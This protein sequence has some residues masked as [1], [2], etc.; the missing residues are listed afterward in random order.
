MVKGLTLGL[1]T[2]ALAAAASAATSYNV[3][4]FEPVVV[5]GTSLKPGEYKVEV[6]ND[7]ATIKRGKTLDESPV[8]IE[9]NEVK[10]PSTSV[11]LVGTQVEEIRV[12]GTKTKL[13]FEKA[14]VATN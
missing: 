7:K 13:V 2:L 1:A 12:G 3:T 9:S 10:Y 6:N 14:G 5:N 8:K 4:F 11:R